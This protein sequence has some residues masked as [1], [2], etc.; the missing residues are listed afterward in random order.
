MC[1]PL[2]VVQPR[3]DG[4]EGWVVIHAHSGMRV[5]SRFGHAEALRIA[6]CLNRDLPALDIKYATDNHAQLIHRILGAAM[7]L[8]PKRNLNQY[9]C[10]ITMQIPVW[11]ESEESARVLLQEMLETDEIYSYTDE[12]EPALEVAKL[13]PGSNFNQPA[14]AVTPSGLEEVERLPYVPVLGDEP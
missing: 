1:Q 9:V 6:E 7:A 14:H 5:G 2:W 12:F 3:S 10:T 13:A 8:R 4:S 11:A